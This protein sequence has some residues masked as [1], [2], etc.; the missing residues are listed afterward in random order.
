MRNG[1]LSGSLSCGMQNT[2]RFLLFSSSMIKGNTTMNIA[3]RSITTNVL[4]RNS[5]IIV[6]HPMEVTTEINTEVTVEATAEVIQD[7]TFK[8]ILEG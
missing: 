3:S 1:N 7:S 6:L 2:D 5:N 4:E 8:A